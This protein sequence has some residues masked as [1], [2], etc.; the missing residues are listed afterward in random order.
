MDA[1]IAWPTRAKQ[2]AISLSHWPVRPILSGF[3]M[4]VRKT[5]MVIT[6]RKPP[7]ILFKLRVTLQAYPLLSILFLLFLTIGVLP[8][9]SMNLTKQGTFLSLRKIPRPTS[10]SKSQN[11]SPSSQISA[12]GQLFI[13]SPTTPAAL[14]PA[15][16]S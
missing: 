7:A 11:M 16:S 8:P 6:R 2:V 10:I 15:K 9:L 3:I 4:A 12:D 5:T 13:I 1:G 14:G